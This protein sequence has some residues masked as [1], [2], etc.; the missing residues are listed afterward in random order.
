VSGTASGTNG[1][2][3]SARILA[4]SSAY[5]VATG[6]QLGAGVAAISVL[7]RVLDRE[8][9]GALTLALV[10]QA[11]LATA[12]AFGLPVA[13]SRIYFRDRGP[14]DARALVGLAVLAAVAM[15]ALAALTGPL[16]SDVFAGLG[17]GAELRLAVL[18]AVPLA[19]LLSAQAYL[20]AEARVRDYVVT[21]AIATVGAQGLGIGI[22]ALGGGPAGYLAGMTAGFVVALW[23]ALAGGRLT[24]VPLR[25]HRGE[26]SLLREALAIGLPTL[27]YA[28]A[29]FLIAAADRILVERQL[30][31]ADAG[32]YYAAYAVG[33]LGIFLATA[34]NRAWAPILFGADGSERWALLAES[35]V[36]VTR[37]AALFTAALALGAPVALWALVPPG[38]GIGT[39]ATVSAVV[40]FS[41]LPLVWFLASYNVVVWSS[42]TVVLAVAAPIALAVNVGACLLL[43][44]PLDLAGAA[45]ATP[46]AYAVLA[47]LTWSRSR[48]MAVVPWDGRALAIAALPGVV[49]V[50]AALLMPTDG[51]WLGAR[52]VAAGLAAVVLAA[53][54]RRARTAV[55][56]SAS[57]GGV[58]GGAGVDGDAAALAVDL[59]AEHAALADAPLLAVEASDLLGE[60]LGLLAEA[61]EGDGEVEQQAEDHREAE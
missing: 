26:R 7:T 45:I 35:A 11:V 34:I 4:R 18:S 57:A 17:F 8:E 5:A 36:A 54:L 24:L 61:G 47:L 25:D 23:F 52:I 29:L 12:G 43:I 21:V 51:P 60:D 6:F 44:P 41:A 19:A 28:L 46:L 10:I 27:P 3:A 16:W 56:G 32:A 38:Y 14:A 49:A 31:L 42:R 15:G 40:A 33:S 20:Q 30:G 58:V 2:T 53:T 13:V 39:L 50:P 48:R 9:Y 59:G 1:G 37:S 22:A 55:T